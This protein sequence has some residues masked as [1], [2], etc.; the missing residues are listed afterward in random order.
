[1][2]VRAIL[3]V[4]LLGSGVFGCAIEPLRELPRE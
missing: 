3:E 2:S 1:M 4:L